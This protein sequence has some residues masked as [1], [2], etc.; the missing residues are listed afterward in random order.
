MVVAVVPSGKYKGRHKGRVTVRAKGSFVVKENEVL[1]CETSYKNLR[2]IQRSD[3][4]VY[5]FNDEVKERREAACS[6]S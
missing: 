1:V 2:V 3:G 5:S 4:Y 6:V